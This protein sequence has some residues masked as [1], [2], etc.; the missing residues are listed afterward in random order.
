MALSTI[1]NNSL[2]DTA[3]HGQRN[4]IIN[5][6]FSVSQRGTSFTTDNVYTIDRWYSGDGSGG[7][8]AR[9]L[10]QETF[11]LG[12]T[13][14]PGA[15]YYLRHNQTGASTNGN[16]SLVH[17]VEDVTRFDGQTVTFSFYAKANAAMDVD[18]R[19]T[20]DFGTGGSPSADVTVTDSLTLGTTWQRYTITKTLGSLSGKTLGTDGVQ[21]SFFRIVFDLTPTTTFTFDL[22]L[23]QLEYGSE[24]TPFEHRSFGDELAR[25]QRYYQQLGGASYAAIGSGMLSSDRA[26]TRAYIAF[27]VTMRTS[28]ST[29]ISGSLTST[30]RT[31]YEVAASIDST[32]S[33]PSSAYMNFS[34]GTAGTA[35]YPTLIVVANGT[36]STLNLDAEL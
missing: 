31:N 32:S 20:Q 21:T 8:P 16:A 19:F 24:P 3:V 1:Q 6:D 29:S 28:P 9:T 27:P 18:F 36:T 23:C 22:A 26:F 25:C 30:D 11:T 15:Y 7:S 10:S 5:G 2:A 13:D 4:L 35:L 17:K 33:S 12:Q 34:H 14:V